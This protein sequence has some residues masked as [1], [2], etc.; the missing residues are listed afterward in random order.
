MSIVIVT[1]DGRSLLEA[2]L[3]SLAEQTYQEFEVIVVD[4]GS[5]DG[6]VEHL[7][8]RY[9]WLRF[10]RLEENHGFAAANNIGIRQASGGY[11]AL[12]NNDTEVVARWL[13]EL[14]GE[15]ERHPETGICASKMILYDKREI[16]DSCG[17]CYS[18]E[19]VPRKIGYLEPASRYSERR[20]VFGASAGASIY[21]RSLLEELGGFDED[22]FLVHED[23][24]LNFRAR[25]LGHVCV[26]V[27]KAVV[28][29]HLSTTIGPE[30]D[31]AVYFSQRNLEYVYFKN[32]PLILL[33][34]YLPLHMIYN[35]LKFLRSVEQGKGTV[36]LKAKLDVVS[37]FLQL[38]AK[39]RVVQESRRVSWQQI[40]RLLT[41]GWMRRT[42][43]KSL[44][45]RL[46]GGSTDNSPVT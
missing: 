7:E 4:N 12:L 46:L 11:I 38:M 14:V 30:S 42:V 3:A 45:A 36:F 16:A 35:V 32:L 29:H 37:N 2:C 40:D 15:L 9:P 41:R 8:G 18:I 31:W 13:E 21:R 26:F 20:Q 23:S 33:L 44:R 6:T 25:L 19:G 10:I 39:R 17:D 28:Y 5:T 34:K 27:P 1:L 43:G 24:D 22:F